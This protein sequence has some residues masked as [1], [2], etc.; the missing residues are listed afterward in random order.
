MADLF[1][2]EEQYTVLDN[3]KS[4]VQTFIGENITS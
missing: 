3:D 4:A 2:R 1:D